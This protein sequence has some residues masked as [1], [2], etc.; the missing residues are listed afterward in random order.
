[1]ASSVAAEP[2]PQPQGVTATNLALP[3]LSPNLNT[4][5]VPPWQPILHRLC[6]LVPM[7]DRFK[8]KNTKKRDLSFRQLDSRN[9]FLPS[10]YIAPVHAE[11]PPSSS[12]EEDES[13]NDS[14]AGDG[15]S[16]GLRKRKA[17]EDEDKE[18]KMT[19]HI[20][21]RSRRTKKPKQQFNPHSR[22]ARS[23]MPDTSSS[24][25]NDSESEQPNSGQRSSGQASI[26]GKRS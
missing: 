21:T 1:M 16:R 14:H 11:D 7:S 17:V 19:K 9:Y 23:N 2:Q 3:D 8:K 15:S 13:D 6:D 22:K 24:D 20:R 5:A 10:T 18:Q 4:P 25:T 26:G 12:D